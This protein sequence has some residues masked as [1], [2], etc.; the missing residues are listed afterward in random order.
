MPLPNDSRPCRRPT[1]AALSLLLVSLLL[2]GWP[3]PAA[4]LQHFEAAPA[5][6]SL[7]EVERKSAGCLGCHQHTD[8]ASMHDDPAVKLGCTDCHGGDAS[9]IPSPGLPR[10]E[11]EY[12]RLRDLAHVLPLLPQEWNYPKSAKPQRSYTLLNRESPA[13]IRFVNP[14]DYRVATQACGACHLSIVAATQRSLMST[15]A[16]L[17]GGASYNNGIL[18]FKR[19]IIGEAY[20]SSGLGAGIE[21]PPLPDPAGA[22]ALHGVLPRLQ[23][24]P[25]WESA[26]PADVFRVFERGGRVTGNRFPEIALPNVAGGLQALNE[27]GRPDLRVSNRGP[28]TAGRVAIPVLNVHKTRLNDP[29]MWFLGTNDQ[30]GDYRGSGCSGCHVVYAN[31]RDELH[32]GPYAKFGNMG[33]SHTIDPV[34]PKHESGHP[35]AHRFT[36]AIPTSQC[37]VCHMHQPN[38]FVNTFMGYTMWDYEAD[39]P[40]MWP[41]KQKY[42]TAEEIRAVN[43]RNPEGAAPR[44]NWADTDFLAHVSEL[45]PSLHDTQFADYHGH[46]WNFRAIFK[47]DRHGNLLDAKGTIV[48]DD[49]PHKF[50]KA[51]H[52]ASIH[53]DKGMHCVDCHFARDNHGNGYIYGEVAQAIE[54]ACIDCHGTVDTYPTLRTSGP[55]APPGGTD[56]ALLRNPS[57]ARRF[58]WRE[59]KLYQHSLVNPGLEWRVHLVK[60]SVDPRSGDYNARAARAKLMSRDN[61]FTGVGPADSRRPARPRNAGYG[62]LLV[63]HLVD[64]ELRRLSPAD[65]GKLED[66]EPSLRRR[67]IARH[68][69]LQ[70]TGGARRHVHAR[71]SRTDRRRTDRTGALELG[72]RRLLDEHQS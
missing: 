5:D 2:C 16:M 20:T 1:L 22:L 59:G 44:G 12:Q 7:A 58:E 64:D 38:V 31:D 37:M 8:A 71:A 15:G 40:S 65:R 18:P 42:P 55:A 47:R 45:N 62:V 23:A 28:G 36:R 56:L 13:F 43:Q 39:A 10:M 53:M 19:Y 46:G 4:P 49:D 69:H 32:S 50:K 72:A 21:G 52:M 60:D 25:Q 66:A 51:V 17:W 48:A 33:E 6:Q 68:R 70:P 24:L 3:A 9:V 30:P 11:L 41:E 29:N 61:P 27:P 35:L 63:P 57:G 67:R 34:I 54:I 14:A 26:P